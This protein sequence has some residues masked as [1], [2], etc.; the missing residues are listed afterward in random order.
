MC[1]IY[2]LKQNH[3]H[4][5]CMSSVCAGRRK[6]AAVGQLTAWF[7]HCS[8]RTE[9]CVLLPMAAASWSSLRSFLPLHLPRFLYLLGFIACGSPKCWGVRPKT[10]AGIPIAWSC[11]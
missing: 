7:P 11:I 2:I 6:P 9:L 3:S 8:S 10:A 1:V 4:P 5:K